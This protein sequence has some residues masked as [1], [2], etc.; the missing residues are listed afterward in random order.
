MTRAEFTA[1]ALL[2]VIAAALTLAPAAP[3]R[4][5]ASA[6]Q[7]KAMWR[8][9]DR[10]GK[11][12]H[13]RGVVS[14]VTSR[15]AWGYVEVADGQC[16]NGIYVLKRRK[17]TR[18]WKVAGAGSDWGAPERCRSDVRKIGRRVLQDL[19]PRLVLTC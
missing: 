19:F 8:V 14:T 18:T 13:H 1:A 15:Y 17:G 9:A 16:G 3:A 5:R 12:V 6:A 7:S 11:C 10:A 4:K 2:C